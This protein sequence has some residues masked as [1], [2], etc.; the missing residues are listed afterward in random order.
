[1]KHAAEETPLPPD[2]AERD[3]ARREEAGP[4]DH[5]IS[6]AEFRFVTRG[7][8]EEE[9][10]AA[11]AVLTQLR[12]EETR[13]AKRVERRDLAPWSRSQREPDRLTGLIADA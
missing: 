7:V 4:V 11:I 2:A 9:R 8:S 5:A 3:A 10:A 1:M 12:A 13:R 6:D